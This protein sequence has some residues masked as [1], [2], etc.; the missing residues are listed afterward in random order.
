MKR[1]LLFFL[2]INMLSLSANEESSH[3]SKRFQDQVVVVTGASR[4]IGR[5]IARLFAKEGAKVV[6]VGRE[7]AMLQ[8]A[9]KEIQE[10]GNYS[11]LIVQTEISHPDEVENLI[12][13]VLAEYGTI[14]V[15]CHNAGNINAVE[16]GNI[17]TEGLDTLGEEHIHNMLR[18]IPLGRLGTPEDVAY[19]ML[20]LASKEADFITGQSLIVDGGQTLPETHFAEY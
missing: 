3:S 8:T 10:G 2:G 1:A 16:P 18:A 6:L 19:A 7:M 15:L 11:S 17:Q 4:G 14:D 12:A 5:G 9:Q 13:Q 20:F